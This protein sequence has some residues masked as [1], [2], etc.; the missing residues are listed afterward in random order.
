MQAP[1][2]NDDDPPFRLIDFDELYPA[3]AAEQDAGADAKLSDSNNHARTSGEQQRR[4]GA[5]RLAYFDEFAMVSLAKQWII[6][7]VIAQG[8]ISSWVGPPGVGK[9]A[10]MSGVAIAAASGSNWR[11]YRTKNNCGVVYFAFE[12]A[13]LV[14]RRFAAHRR[15]DSLEGLPIAV[16]GELFDLMNPNCVDII[17]DTIRAAGQTFGRGVGLVIIDTYNKGIAFGGGDEDK[18]RDQNRAQANLRKVVERTNVHIACVGHTGK[19]ETRGE[20]GSSARPADL[21]LLVQI[22][23]NAGGAKTATVIKANDQPLGP[24][25]IV[26]L[27]PFNLGEDDDGDPVQIFIVDEEIINAAAAKPEKAPARL[28]KAAKIALDALRMALDELGAVPEASNHIPANTRTVSIENWRKYAYAKGIS[29]GEERAKQ[30]A[31][32]RATE[33]LIANQHVAV[34]NEQVWPT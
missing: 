15:R 1:D 20:R 19:D 30:Q 25:T 13:D 14:R 10:L 4:G 18:A 24:L 6:K 32:R 23:G 21:D 11:G 7:N 17:V 27:E 9:S 33:S 31:F 8:E 5:L 16:A 26:Q 34:W 2:D 12:R 28:P 29:A 22:T 3:K